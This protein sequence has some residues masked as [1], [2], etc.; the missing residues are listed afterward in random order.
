MLGGTN[1]RELGPY[2]N[3]AQV[4]M[5][6]VSPIVLGVVLDLALGWLPW[7]TI[8]GA[9]VGFPLGLFHLLSLLKKQDEKQKP[10]RPPDQ[11]AR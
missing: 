3:M 2:L 4:G 6:M 7:L 8:I 10:T 5:E 9:A 11:V 1:Q